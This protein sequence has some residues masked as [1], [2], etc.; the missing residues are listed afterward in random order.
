MKIQRKIVVSSAEPKTLARLNPDGTQI[1]YLIP[2]ETQTGPQTVRLLRAPVQGGASQFILESPDITN[3]Q[4][5]RAP[6]NVCLFGRLESKSFTFVAFDPEKGT[7]REVGKLEQPAR[8][9]NWSLSPVGTTIGAAELNG[10]NRQIHLIS[11]IGQP[12]RTITLKDWNNLLSL[13]WAADGKGFFVSTNPTG[14]LSALL[15]VDL[16]G[17]AHSLWQQKNFQASWGIPS[18]DGK[19]V[20]IAE[21]TAECNAWMVEKFLR[22]ALS[23]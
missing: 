8:G 3:L 16:A 9:W 22:A 18:H 11:L 23:L 10:T 12:S 5:S 6:A 21:P 20:A 4:C 7:Q 19:Y 14:H 1:I 13:D 2:P 17:N 15:Y